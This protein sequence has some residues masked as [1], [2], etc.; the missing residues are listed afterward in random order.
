MVTRE[1]ITTEAA[2]NP[3]YRSSREWNGPA[4][5]SKSAKN[6]LDN[7]WLQFIGRKAPPQI[8]AIGH[9]DINDAFRHYVTAAFVTQ[10][11]AKINHPITGFLGVI[12]AGDIA[13]FIAQQ[14]GQNTPSAGAM[15]QNNNRWGARAGLTGQTDFEIVMNFMND[16]AASKLQV[17]DEHGHLRQTSRED[18]P[19]VTVDRVEDRYLP[20]K[21]QHG[22]GTGEVM[23][24]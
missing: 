10:V 9:D 3:T 8:N 19:H 17:L 6:P 22:D 2:I 14:L 20:E 7:A 16:V 24:A 5:K 21:M 23:I 12:A 1:F 18:L 11:L 13:E 4:V 15:D